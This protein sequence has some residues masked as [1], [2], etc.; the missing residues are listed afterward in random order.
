MEKK[1][2]H[3]KSH[4][5]CGFEKLRKR[6][7]EKKLT[8][9][10]T[11]AM[12]CTIPDNNNAD[13]EYSSYPPLNLPSQYIPLHRIGQGSYG[14]V[15]EA[16]DSFTQEK[17]AVKHIQKVFQ[18][19]REAKQTLRE[20]RHLRILRGNSN[21]LFLKD[22]VIGPPNSNKSNF[23]D[24]YLITPL[25]ENGDLHQQIAN[26]S[27]QTWDEK[28]LKHFVLQLLTG[29][30]NMHSKQTIHRDL[31]P[32]NILLS[33][34]DC[35]LQNVIIC[36][37]GMSRKISVKMS[38]M[39]FTTTKWYRPPEGF[40]NENAYNT[41]V[42]VW[43]AG[44]I[45][46][47][48]ITGKRLFDF[49]PQ[50][51]LQQTLQ[52]LFNVV[53]YPTDP[54]DI[55]SIRGLKGETVKKLIREEIDISCCKNII[56][57]LF[58]EHQQLGKLV[59]RMLAF[60]LN[61]RCTAEDAVKDEYFDGMRDGGGGGVE[62]ESGKENERRGGEKEKENEVCKKREGGEEI[63]EEGELREEFWEELEKLKGASGCL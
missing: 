40:Y 20:L 54:Q 29:L 48:I 17:V 22:V 51:S 63:K 27:T 36:D 1:K 4:S 41:T 42:D 3:K 23:E 50:E 57:E 12:S 62:E 13:N 34:T 45:I 10:L 37:L 7:S 38:L 2:L 9:L 15:W 32:K 11:L 30:K 14:I 24:L 26:G 49:K 6:Q 21:L 52:T 25:A 5:S 35:N 16:V 60:N 28:Q 19:L 55:E 58:S 33:K 39:E 56:P 43:A 44:C 61:K 47:E 46:S 53:G 18:D 59:E 31:R 8:S